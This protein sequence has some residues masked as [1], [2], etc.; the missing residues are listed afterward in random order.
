[1]IS[2]SVAT[3]HAAAHAFCIEFV[4]AHTQHGA[5]LQVVRFGADATYLVATSTG[6]VFTFNPKLLSFVYQ[7]VDDMR[8][9][10]FP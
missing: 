7:V 6:L 8:L 1:M 10:D 4:Y 5:I 9:G 3:D 2:R